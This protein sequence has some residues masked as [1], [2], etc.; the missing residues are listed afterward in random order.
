MPD[1]RGYLIEVSSMNLQQ[2]EEQSFAEQSA[3][4]SAAALRARFV[5]FAFVVPVLLALQQWGGPGWDFNLTPVVCFGLC[6]AVLF[7]LRRR[8]FVLRV[9]PFLFV[10]DVLL[11]FEVQRRSLQSSPF[12]AGVAGFSLGLFSLLISLTGSTM[13]VPPIVLVAA[14]AIPAQVTLMRLAGVSAGAQVLAAFVLLAVVSTQTGINARLRRMVRSMASSEIAWRQEH[15][16]VTE[17]LEARATIE[18]LLLEARAQNA[19]LV[20]LQA[21]KDSLT[22]LLVHD[23]RAPLGAV[24]ANLDWIG[25][26]LPAGSDPEIISAVS[27]S[28]QVTD[29]LSGMIGDLLNISQL[30]RGA[31]QLA[32][33]AKPCS[34]MLAA[35]HRQLQA[36]ARSRRISVEFQCDDVILE[37][38]HALLMRALE[39]IASN[40]LRY[41]P[42][43]GRLR[44]E[45]HQ[46]GDAVV[47]SVRNDGPV[48]PQS[49]RAG[50]FEKYVQAGSA[51][52]NRRAG[53]G[54][55]LYF[56]RLCMDA[57]G[58]TIGVVDRAGWATSFDLRVPGASA[59]RLVA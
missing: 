20:T 7:A 51:G 45:A 44:L 41:T 49:K 37:A 1:L 22:S 23:L 29:R 38:D 3:R 42:A 48:I 30:E 4:A 46:E 56:C 19:E 57:H 55:G 2:A 10:L 32:R 52:D 33:E 14:A 6:S 36:Q 53:W 58:G 16:Q 15:Q 26:E 24:R 11:V 5:L 8:A 21:E 35:L 31:L 17:L 9:S 12:P 18:R 40:A 54:L 25:G 43:G 47:Y 34:E 59:P 27:E 50:L 39:N 13:R 28:R